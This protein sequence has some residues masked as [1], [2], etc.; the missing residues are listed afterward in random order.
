MT[1]LDI[2]RE[3][4]LLWYRLFALGHPYAESGAVVVQ[5]GGVYR[6]GGCGNPD[7]RFMHGVVGLADT[8]FE[9]WN[10][11]VDLSSLSYEWGDAILDFAPLASHSSL[12]LVVGP[13]CEHGLATLFFGMP[14]TKRAIQRS[15]VFAS[16]KAARRYLCTPPW[17]PRGFSRQPP[18]GEREHSLAMALRGA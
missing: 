1:P 15:G 8:L 17:Q 7:A 6:W 18:P 11:I 9:P 16:V 10:L 14:T 4:P 5:F 13:D 12:A 3:A 2:T